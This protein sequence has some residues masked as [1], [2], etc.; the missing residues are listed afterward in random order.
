MKNTKYLKRTLIISSVLSLAIA[1]PAL[2]ASTKDE[3]KGLKEEINTLQQG[4]EEI[5]NNLAEI[6]KLLEQ[7]AARAPAAPAAKT[8]FEPTDILVGDVALLGNADAG[9][10][11]IGYSDYQCPYCSRH[12]TKV[13]PKIVEQ[14]VDSGKLRIVMREYPIESIHP[15][16]FAAS[17]TAL[18][19]GAQGKYWEMHDLIFTNQKSLS[20]DDFKAHAETLGM[21]ATAFEACLA[22]ENSSRRIRVKLQ[23]GQRVGVSG[24]PSFVVGLTDPED[25]NKVH[26]TK[27]VRGAQPLE[28]FTEAIDELL[29]ENEAE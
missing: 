29:A 28:V 15:R 8:A 26:V 1:L 13:L 12:A 9:V 10:T 22:D 2:A 11:M 3:I 14:Y 7:G 5:Q 21:D 16:A 4:Q 19:A 23:E 17:L 20:D 24:T 6:K 27:F 18:C 25:S